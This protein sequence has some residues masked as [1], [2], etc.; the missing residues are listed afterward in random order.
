MN[1]AD[2]PL[3]TNRDTIIIDWS[4]VRGPRQVPW[5]VLDMV[6]LGLTSTGAVVSLVVFVLLF[7]W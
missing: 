4:Q 3:D 5:S 7:K 2:Q 1:R 6:L